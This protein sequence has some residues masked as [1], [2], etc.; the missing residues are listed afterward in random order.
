MTPT[1]WETVELFRFTNKAPRRWLLLFDDG[2][3][4]VINQ[5]NY[6]G[7]HIL[8]AN[9]LVVVKIFQNLTYLNLQFGDF[10]AVLQTNGTPS[11]SR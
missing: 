3:K 9:A 11:P 7:H 8:R 6:P 10:N 4:D 5:R 1:N 2:F